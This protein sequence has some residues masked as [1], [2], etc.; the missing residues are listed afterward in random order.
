MRKILD[1]TEVVDDTKFYSI[2]MLQLFIGHISQLLLQG[3]L[4]GNES[5]REG[6]SSWEFVQLSRV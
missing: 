4:L 6:V 5:D 2:Q 3:I 1:T